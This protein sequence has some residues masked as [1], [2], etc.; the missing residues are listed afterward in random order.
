MVVVHPIQA[1]IETLTLFLP[2]ELLYLAL[3]VAGREEISR[4]VPQLAQRQ[5]C[6]EGSSPS[7]QTY[8]RRN[9]RSNGIAPTEQQI[10]AG[11]Q[12]QDCHYCI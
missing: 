4:Q 11:Y 5:G 12:T 1:A 10:A 3:P 6:K 8:R 2:E 9:V 7:A